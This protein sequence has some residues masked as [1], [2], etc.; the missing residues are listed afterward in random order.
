MHKAWKLNILTIFEQGF[1]DT[2]TNPK[3][4]KRRKDK[5]MEQHRMDLKESQDNFRQ[6]SL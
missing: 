3:M 5:G 6:Y 4:T 1:G 2:M